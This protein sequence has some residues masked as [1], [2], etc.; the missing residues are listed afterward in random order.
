MMAYLMAIET[1]IY[2]IDQRRKQTVND[3][4]MD[5]IERNVPGVS[6]SDESNENTHVKQSYFT[7]S[8][9]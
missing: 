4:I 2:D 8:N 5:D 1:E 6:R 3:R 9:P 7:V